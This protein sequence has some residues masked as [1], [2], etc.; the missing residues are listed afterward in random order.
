MSERPPVQEPADP[1]TREADAQREVP[2]APTLQDLSHREE[3]PAAL[4]QEDD[5]LWDDDDLPSW[6]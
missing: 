4:G 3:D 1:D 5:A 6:A 2:E